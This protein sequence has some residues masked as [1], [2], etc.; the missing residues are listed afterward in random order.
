MLD[1]VALNQVSVANDSGVVV[2][3]GKV[4]AFVGAQA[5]LYDCLVAGE[6]AAFILDPASQG[7]G[8]LV[9]NAG[10]VFQHAPTN[11]R[12]A[13]PYCDYQQLPLPGPVIQSG[14][15]PCASANNPR[16][17]TESVLFGQSV[18]LYTT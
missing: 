10:H 11:V 6:V 14:T 15:V 18:C 2:G 16:V 7:L 13:E 5:E 1:D 3:A 4:Q 9:T 17:L 8:Y 12:A